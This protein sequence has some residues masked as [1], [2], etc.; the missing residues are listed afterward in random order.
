MKLSIILP[1]LNEECSIGKSIEKIELTFKENN[2][3]GEIIIVD[4]NST[5][6]SA[7]VAKQYKINYIFEKKRGYGNAYLAGLNKAKGEYII[8]GDP[9]GSYD[10]NEI[11][12]FLKELEKNDFIVGSRYLGKMKKGAMPI[13]HKYIGNPIIRLFLRLN[14]LK[15]KETCTG[16]IGINKNILK[17]INPKQTG[18]EFSS[19][20]LV[21]A[22]SNNITIKEIPITYH[23][24]IGKSKINEIRDGLRHV[25]FLSRYKLQI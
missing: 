6:N 12:N 5:D 2:L 16:F 9:D 4:N 7:K 20:L 22:K 14:G 19:E 24:R 23:N 1:C 17:I 13:S 25:F 18:M 21:K 10:F 3:N 11:P 8:M 15:M